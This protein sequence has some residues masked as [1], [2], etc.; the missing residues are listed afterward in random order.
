MDSAFY[1]DMRTEDLGQ[2]DAC[3]SKDRI[4]DVSEAI[5]AA[6]SQYISFRGQGGVSSND[7]CDSTPCSMLAAQQAPLP[8][9][10]EKELQ[11]RLR[12]VQRNRFWLCFVFHRV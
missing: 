5:A 10:H 3:K 9:G 8:D 11:A 1:C 4:V 6:R 7:S 12:R 2:Q